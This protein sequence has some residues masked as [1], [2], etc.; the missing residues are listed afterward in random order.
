[1]KNLFLINKSTWPILGALII[2]TLASFSIVHENGPNAVWCS[3]FQ[4][5]Q[6][7]VNHHQLMQFDYDKAWKE[8]ED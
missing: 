6:P 8:I 1:M 7:P 2:A 3:F 5:D 4:N